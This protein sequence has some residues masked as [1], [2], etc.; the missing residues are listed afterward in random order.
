VVRP[1]GGIFDARARSGFWVAQRLALRIKMTLQHH[2]KKP[3]ILSEAEA[4]A[5]RR[6]RRS[7]RTPLA[8]PRDVNERN[9][10][11]STTDDTSG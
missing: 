4:F 10:D 2:S 6:F 9:P 7:Q 3:A 1:G 11:L 5:P 8:L